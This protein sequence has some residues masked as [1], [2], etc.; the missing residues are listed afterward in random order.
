[1]TVREYLVSKGISPRRLKVI[2]Y[3]EDR[4]I[5]SNDTKEG[6]AENRRVELKI[7]QK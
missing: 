1:M 3:G 6:R 5:G 4:P 2:A 7:L